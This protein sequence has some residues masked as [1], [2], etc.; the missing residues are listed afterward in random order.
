MSLTMDPQFNAFLSGIR[1]DGETAR[2][3]IQAHSQLSAMI[4]NDAD[5]KG[6]IVV[7][8]LQG[9]YRRNTI[10]RPDS[11]HRSDVDVVVV[12]TLSHD[13][14]DPQAALDRFCP[15]VDRNY[16]NAW[17]QQGRSIGI[18]LDGIDLDLVITAAPTLEQIE[19]LKSRSVSATETV[20]ETPD[21]EVSRTWRPEGE[22]T[23]FDAVTRT[24][25]EALHTEPWRAEPLLIPDRDLRLWQR[26]HPL[27]QIRWTVEKNGKT[28]RLFLD[29]VK[30]LKWWRRVNFPGVKHPKGYPYEHMIGDCC[31][32]GITSISEGVTLTLETMWRTYQP[33]SLQGLV[34]FLPDRGV[35][36]HNVL[37]RLE[38]A[39]FQQFCQ[40]LYQ[41]AIIARKAFDATDP[42]VAA[43]GWRQL[44]GESFPVPPQATRGG[45]SPAVGPGVIGSGRFG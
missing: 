12:T 44:L 4:K 17:K 19:I 38:L 41:A 43:Q 7:V 15:F 10:V 5:V 21:W 6:L 28:A 42:Q 37:H 3:I 32:D 30:A 16:P 34:P 25:Q 36:E 1:L 20:D 14:Y 45:F 9:S 39:A 23:P 2:R 27:E 24:L 35:P 22:R 26:T 13:Q 40:Q 8:F 31:P 29:V 11:G 33:C 18:H